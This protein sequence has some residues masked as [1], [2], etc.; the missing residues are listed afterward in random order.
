MRCCRCVPTRTL[1]PGTQLG[2]FW[3]GPRRRWTLTKIGIW[4]I[5]TTVLVVQSAPGWGALGRVRMSSGCRSTQK[6][7]PYS[8]FLL[9]HWYCTIPGIHSYGSGKELDFPHLVVKTSIRQSKVCALAQSGRGS[10][11]SVVLRAT[12]R[13]WLMV[14]EINKDCRIRCKPLIGSSQCNMHWPEYA[15]WSSCAKLKYTYNITINL[16]C[17]IQMCLCSV[18]SHSA[19]V[20]VSGIGCGVLLEIEVCNVLYNSY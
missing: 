7:I 6:T 8:S 1:W 12:I 16:S 17:A 14:S 5:G 20:K 11:W 2:A 3:H 15:N 10:L 13:L 9:E 19:N 18:N 4:R